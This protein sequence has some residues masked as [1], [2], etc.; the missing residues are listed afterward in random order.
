MLV[1]QGSEPECT[2]FED[3][4]S[5]LWTLDYIWF[6][7]KNLKVTAAL[8]TLPESAIAAYGGFPNEY[9]PS[10]HF[11]MKAHFKFLDKAA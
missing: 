9:F 3:D 5:R 4:G 11:S 2:G 6:D 1:F 10:D 8:E 7:S